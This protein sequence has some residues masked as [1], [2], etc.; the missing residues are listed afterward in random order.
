MNFPRTVVLLIGLPGSGKTTLAKR[1]QEYMGCPWFNADK[2]RATLSEDLDFSEKS[3]LL[4]A[5]RMAQ[6][7]A[8]TLEYETSNLV[9]ADFVCPTRAMRKIGRASCRERVSSPV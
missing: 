6:I 2:V 9:I 3:R 8:L 1:L 5:R 7:C 4:Q